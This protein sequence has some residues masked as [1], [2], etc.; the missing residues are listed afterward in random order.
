MPFRKS[1]EINGDDPPERPSE[2]AACC[3]NNSGLRPARRREDDMDIGEALDVAY[4]SMNELHR[5]GYTN[6]DD[7]RARAAETLAEAFEDVQRRLNT[8]IYALNTSYLDNLS[9]DQKL[10]ILELCNGTTLADTTWARE[11]AK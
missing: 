1:I 7:A 8:V 4:A 11:R 10:F 9:D 3:R 6:S 2:G 5:M